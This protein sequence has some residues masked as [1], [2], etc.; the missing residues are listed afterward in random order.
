MVRCKASIICLNDSHLERRFTQE[1]PLHLVKRSRV[2]CKAPHILLCLFSNCTSLYI[3]M[4]VSQFHIVQP[5]FIL[6]SKQTNSEMQFNR[7]TSV[8]NPVK[9]STRVFEKGHCDNVALFQFSVISSYSL[10]FNCISQNLFFIVL[11]TFSIR[12]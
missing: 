9:V 1:S 8:S 3:T 6:Y 5:L 12:Y 11:I 2:I 4:C 7:V 10:F